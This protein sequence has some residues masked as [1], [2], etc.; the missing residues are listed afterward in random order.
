M[1]I[2]KECNEKLVSFISVLNLQS[3]FVPQKILD[4]INK[5]PEMKQAVWSDLQA[6]QRE[7]AKR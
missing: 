4:S 1:C 3:A 5:N 2:L 6:I 7:L